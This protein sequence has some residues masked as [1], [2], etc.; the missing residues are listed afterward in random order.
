MS[1]NGPDAV[2]QTWAIE[3]ILAKAVGDR[4]APFSCVA[5]GP[6][7]G[8]S[9]A[10]AAARSSPGDGASGGAAA[11]ADG[12][13]LERGADKAELAGRPDGWTAGPS[14]LVAKARTAHRNRRMPVRRVIR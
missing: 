4:E 14:V 5:R 13:A 8:R 3:R 10:S 7:S 6:G 1:D 12:R 2:R 11:T 9:T